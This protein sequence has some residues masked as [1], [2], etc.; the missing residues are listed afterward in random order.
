[1]IQPPALA[2]EELEQDS[3]TIDFVPS[4]NNYEKIDIIQ[5]G[6]LYPSV[7]K[8]VTQ[9]SQEL[10]FNIAYFGRATLGMVSIM[11]EDGTVN[12]I[13][14]EGYS[15]PI[16][17]FTVNKG[18]SDYFY[19]KQI[20]YTLKKNLAIVS[21]ITAERH[22]LVVGDKI[23]F[24]SDTGDDNSLVI[25]LIVP[26][27]QINWTEILISRDLGY[28]FDIYRIKKAT[29][30]GNRIDEKLYIEL[31]KNIKTKKIQYLRKTDLNKGDW[32]LPAALLKNE[33]GEFGVKNR[34]SKWE[35]GK[36]RS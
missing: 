2:N 1:M 15:I 31:Y 23:S 22:N 34:D 26:D 28:E 30:W 5:S 17:V 19:G 25:G 36:C 8:A 21:K 18:V 27:K 7:V 29:L 12:E 6:S 35:M 20:S 3:T 33:F 11:K 32:I 24:M 14:K 9:I 10:N 4:I 16:S 13:V